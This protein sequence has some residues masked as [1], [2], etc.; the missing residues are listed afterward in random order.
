MKPSP[1]SL[2]CVL[3]PGATAVTVTEWISWRYSCQWTEIEQLRTAVSSYKWGKGNVQGGLCQ[4][5]WWV[6]NLVFRKSSCCSCLTVWTPIMHRAG[7]VLMCLFSWIIGARV[8]VSNTYF[9]P[10]HFSLFFPVLLK[11]RLDPV[12]QYKAMTRP[13]R[14]WGLGG[15]LKI[16]ANPSPAEWSSLFIHSNPQWKEACLE[17][18]L[19]ALRMLF[20]KWDVVSISSMHVIKRSCNIMRTRPNKI[21]A[22]K[23]RQLVN[24]HF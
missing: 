13:S 7:I 8:F 19:H 24:V 10:F 20:S 17:N 11:A 16:C 5:V 4:P 9:F 12:D 1:G 3:H 2:P 21:Y 6:I 23:G 14:G 15:A 18:E 22:L